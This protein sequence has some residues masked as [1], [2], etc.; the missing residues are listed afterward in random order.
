[1]VADR[2]ESRSNSNSRAAAAARGMRT[3]S[4]GGVPR[5]MHAD[6]GGE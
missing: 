5:I 4:K 2:A 1:M 3:I 6:E